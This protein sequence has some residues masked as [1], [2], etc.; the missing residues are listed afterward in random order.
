M[1]KTMICITFYQVADEFLL[2]ILTHHNV[3]YMHS[4]DPPPE[5]HKKFYTL[6]KH[7]LFFFFFNL[8]SPQKLSYLPEL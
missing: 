7:T 1:T 5:G 4:T 2:K 8:C 6:S 3:K